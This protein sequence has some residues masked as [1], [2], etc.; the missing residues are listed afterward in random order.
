MTEAK[1]LASSGVRL[2]GGPPESRESIRW[3]GIRQ[4]QMTHYYRSEH[5][6]K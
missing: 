6:D 2:A 4:M 3:V 5:V 1:T